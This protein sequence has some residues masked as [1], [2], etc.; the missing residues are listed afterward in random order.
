MSLGL[1]SHVELQEMMIGYVHP[2]TSRTRSVVI[3]HQKVETTQCEISLPFKKP[4]LRPSIKL[5][6]SYFMA[7]VYPHVLTSLTRFTDTDFIWK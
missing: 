6:E 5:T 3:Q 2:P 1:L 7:L 4:S